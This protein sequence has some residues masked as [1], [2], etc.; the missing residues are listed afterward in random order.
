MRVI[1]LQNFDGYRKGQELE[2]SNPYARAVIAKGIAKEAPAHLNQ[3]R[4]GMQNKG[5]SR[6]AGA[7]SSASRA[8]RASQQTTARSSGDGENLGQGGLL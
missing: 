8:V 2:L 3:M 1:A 6:T 7:P 5:P 4:G